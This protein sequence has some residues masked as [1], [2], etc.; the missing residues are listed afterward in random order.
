MLKIVKAGRGEL[1]P[2]ASGASEEE[3]GGDLLLHTTLGVRG[4]SLIYSAVKPGGDV[5]VALKFARQEFAHPQSLCLA[6]KK[7]NTAEFGLR[8]LQPRTEC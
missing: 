6:W 7:K 3:P 4:D 1:A 8:L 2:F 5:A